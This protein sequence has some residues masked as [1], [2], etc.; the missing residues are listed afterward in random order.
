VDFLLVARYMKE[1]GRSKDGPTS[2][3]L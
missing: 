3:W 2:V 1:F